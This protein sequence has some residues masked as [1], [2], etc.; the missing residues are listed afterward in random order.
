MRV[1][2]RVWVSEYYAPVA[3]RVRFERTRRDFHRAVRCGFV[4][5]C[6]WEGGC[7]V[8]RTKE[9]CCP[10]HSQ[11]SAQMFYFN[12]ASGFFCSCDVSYV[13]FSQSTN[14]ASWFQKMWRSHQSCIS[15]RETS[16][17]MNLPHWGGCCKESCWSSRCEGIVACEVL[18]RVLNFEWYI[19]RS[20][21]TST[22]G[23]HLATIFCIFLLGRMPGRNDSCDK[24]E[25]LM[26]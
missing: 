18:V 9:N 19:A 10:F 20:K 24:L 15:Y 25:L 17:L 6:G 2:M 12:M 1:C 21:W 3:G 13:C 14:M 4:F 26:T 7:T 11:R 16:C 5:R 22:G 23:A 8:W